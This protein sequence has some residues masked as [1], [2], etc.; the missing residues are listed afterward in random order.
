MSGTVKW[1]NEV[2]LIDLIEVGAKGANLGE[3]IQAGFN[4]PDGF[5]VTTEA[6]SN[7]MAQNAL[8]NRVL[9]IVEKIDLEDVV[10]AEKMEQAIR[11]LYLNAPTVVDL[12]RDIMRAYEKLCVSQTDC[13]DDTSVAIRSSAVL[14]DL[15][16]ASFVGQYDTYLYVNRISL[17]QYIRLCWAS[18]WG[19]RALKYR[20]KQGLTES[21]NVL[22]VLI[23]KMIPAQVS[24]VLFTA[25]PITGNLNEMVVNSCWGLCEGITSGLISPDYFEIDKN[26]LEI[27]KREI[28]EQNTEIILD[29]E[30]GEGTTRR[31]IEEKR[32]NMPS[33]TD[34]QVKEL[35]EIGKRV[36]EW[37]NSPQN[38]EWVYY[39]DKFYILQ[40]RSISDLPKLDNYAHPWG[41]ITLWT[42]ANLEEVV[43]GVLTASTWSM[44]NRA[45]EYAFKEHLKKIELPPIEGKLE[46]FRYTNIFHS[47][48]YFNLSF[49]QYL[50]QH[51]S[52][53][54]AEYVVNMFLGQKENFQDDNK[55]WRLRLPGQKL[56]RLKRL[57]TV[58]AELSQRIRSASA[59][60]AEKELQVNKIYSEIMKSDLSSKNNSELAVLLE[61]YRTLFDQLMSVHI[62]CS[63][64][65]G[66]FY[67][68]LGKLTLI[69]FKDQQGVIQSKLVSGL[70][71]LES[72]KMGIELW[73]LTKIVKESQPLME[74]FLNTDANQLLNTLNQSE[75]ATPFIAELQK[76]LSQYGFHGVQEME[77]MAPSWADE[78]TFVLE[79][80]KRYLCVNESISPQ[81]IFQ[82]QRKEREEL[83]FSIV[84][85]IDSIL[86]A[87]FSSMLQQVFRRTLEYAQ[88]GI[89]LRENGKATLVRVTSLLRL[90]MRELSVRFVSENVINECDDVFF[91]TIQEVIQLASEKNLNIPPERL[92]RIRRAEYLRDKQFEL[93]EVVQVKHSDRGR[94]DKEPVYGVNLELDSKKDALE[95]LACSPGCITGIAKVVLHP[96]SGGKLNPGEI[97][98]APIT[99]PDWTPLLILAGG[100]VVDRG[101]LLSHGSNIAREYGIPVVADVKVGTKLIIDGQEI[102]VDGNT[103]NVFL[104]K[105]RKSLE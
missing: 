66:A 55:K 78:P 50:A 10:K 39:R 81:E 48:A 14:E 6:Y 76:F 105:S 96:S 28:T 46:A 77:L 97:L 99:D 9:D 20:K 73:R 32:A 80:I 64:L 33:L 4:V 93:P 98:V 11:Q 60:H 23:Q 72:S 84:K 15:P 26:S 16:E 86:L 18:L 22:G 70:E 24:G 42:H 1:L 27:R 88:L 89:T 104:H 30:K 68:I 3:L 43:P 85:K 57:E 82:R 51:V 2:S 63:A 79:A 102:T 49:F 52:E 101:S 74:I 8:H 13:R 83:V 95:G 92:V 34:E 7:F 65:A 38:I 62:T 36:E 41:E 29:I 67:Y 100:V 103:G 58:V 61:E 21:E 19:K 37:Y 31:T 75:I 69:W 54:Q 17:L 94:E 44:A 87:R 91:F 45:L 12:E 71:T 40:S 59:E 5:C 56:K 47:R 90:I 25:N 35:Y 53:Q